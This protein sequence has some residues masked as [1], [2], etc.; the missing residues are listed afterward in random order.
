MSLDQERLAEAR[1]Q[2]HGGRDQERFNTHVHEPRDS[3]RCA[4]GVQRGK[5]QVSGESSLDCNL[6]SLKVADFADQYDVWILTQ[7]CA[8]GRGEIQPDLL[9]HLDLVNTHE[10]KFNR[11]FSGHDV[12]VRLIQSRN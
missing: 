1:G 4:V 6:S 10:L 3:F 8:Q 12:G 5:H 2:V 7:K 11:V 9:F